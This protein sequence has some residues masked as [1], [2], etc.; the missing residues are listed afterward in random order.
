MTPASVVMTRA[1]VDATDAPVVETGPL[2]ARA[3]GPVMQD[4][5]ASRLTHA[6]QTFE[7]GARVAMT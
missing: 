4:R 1:S 5:H 2:V 6:P 7:T 3:D